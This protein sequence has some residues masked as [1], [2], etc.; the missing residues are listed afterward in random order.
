MENAIAIKRNDI[1]QEL[2][3][4]KRLELLIKR[5]VKDANKTM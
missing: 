2:I 5:I 3:E 1:P 4:A